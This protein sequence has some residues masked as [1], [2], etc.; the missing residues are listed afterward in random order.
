MSTVTNDKRDAFSGTH[1]AKFAYSY[2]SSVYCRLPQ[3]TGA[4]S[5]KSM[6]VTALSRL[7][8]ARKYAHAVGKRAAVNQECS[9]AFNVKAR[10]HEW[11]EWQKSRRGGNWGRGGW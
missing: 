7:V 6:W 10:V 3:P 5:G 2:K 4:P 1:M 9:T 8:Q 11:A